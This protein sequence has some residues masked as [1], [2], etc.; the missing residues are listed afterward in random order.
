MRIS[1]SAKETYTTCGFK[2]FLHY[3]RKLRSTTLKSSLTFGDA[4]DVGLN[5]LLKTRNLDEA[6]E[7]FEHRWKT[8]AYGKTMSYSK[9]DLEEHLVE[10]VPNE[11]KNYESL[12]RKGKILL[13]E[14]NTQIMPRIKE[15]IDIQIDRV[16]ANEDGDEL[17]I[18]TDFICIWEDGRRVL[19]DNKT[20]SVRYEDDSVATSPQ[21]SIYYEQLKNEYN[22]DAAG[23]IVIPKRINKKKEPL[24]LIKII[25]D[26][27]SDDTVQK[28]LAS[29]D[30]V[31]TSIKAAE[32]PKN[33][34]NCKTV[35]GLCDYYKLCHQNDKT[36][37]KE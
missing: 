28:T 26:N 30:Q 37:L 8:N 16:V 12:M 27:V 34:D 5:H 21:L 14:Y 9:S 11:E 10:D 22:L 6:V 23:Y 29:Y 2:Y 19:F 35:F 4:I 13:K 7:R 18:K 31:L 20:S 25:I 24:A 1:H 17:V 36:G 15:V 32:F 3:Y 33:H